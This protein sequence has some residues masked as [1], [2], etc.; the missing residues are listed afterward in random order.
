MFGR[1]S[2]TRYNVSGKSLI[3]HPSDED[4]EE[5]FQAAELRH[6]SRKASV[7]TPCLCSHN[8][9]GRLHDESLISSN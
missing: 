6:T 5:L 7:C 3:A 8:K 9:W 2:M 1:A 4:E